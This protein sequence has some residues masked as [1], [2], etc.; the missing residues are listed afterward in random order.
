MN[1]IKNLLFGLLIVIGIFPDSQKRYIYEL[2]IQVPVLREK[3][4]L[5]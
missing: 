5:I 3:T 2:R 4:V 1:I